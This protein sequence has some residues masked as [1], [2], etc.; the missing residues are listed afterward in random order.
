MIGNRTLGHH[1]PQ[2]ESGHHCTP[3]D[4]HGSVQNKIFSCVGDLGDFLSQLKSVREASL[5]LFPVIKTNEI[6]EV[7]TR[8]LGLIEVPNA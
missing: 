1:V 5:E 7:E 6:L 2:K 8:F 4:T 3:N